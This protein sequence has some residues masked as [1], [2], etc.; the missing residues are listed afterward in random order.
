MLPP[1][2]TLPLTVSAASLGNT[3]V[4]TYVND[5]GGR[6]QLS[7]NC[8]GIRCELVPQKKGT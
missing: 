3:P 8:S 1:K 5:Y 2:S 4:L 6:P 7:F